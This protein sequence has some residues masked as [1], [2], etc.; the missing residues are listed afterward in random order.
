[1]SQEQ[2]PENRTDQ[3]ESH[4]QHDEYGP[5]HGAI[6]FAALMLIGYIAYYAFIWIEVFIIRGA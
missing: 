4:D 6:K 1:M 2:E 3:T 5:P